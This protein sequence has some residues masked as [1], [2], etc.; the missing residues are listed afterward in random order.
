[1]EVFEILKDR[2]YQ[3]GAPADAMEWS[4]ILARKTDVVVDLFG[5][6]DP[7]VP[8][9]P[10]SI[11]YI[12]W[13][14]E[15]RPHLPDVQVMNILVDTVVRLIR[16]GHRVLVHCHKGRSRSG[17]INA[18]VVR[19]LEI[20]GAEAVDLV[21]RQRPESLRNQVFATYVQG[22]PAPTSAPTE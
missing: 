13:P 2:L 4:P 18:L 22:L 16:A 6:L 8:T 17:M 10:D 15:D 9:Q 12:F 11:L 7:G 14:I 3:S 21:R 19:Q 1:L 20:S 5:T